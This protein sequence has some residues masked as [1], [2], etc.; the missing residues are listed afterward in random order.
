MSYELGVIAFL[1]LLLIFYQKAR[2]S[3]AGLV[4]SDLSLL[5]TRI[6]HYKPI[7]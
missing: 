1:Y 4:V 7:K 3:F 6:P 5:R 2:L